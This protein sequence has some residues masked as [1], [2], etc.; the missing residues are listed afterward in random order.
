MDKIIKCPKCG[1]KAEKISLKDELRGKILRGTVFVDPALIST[2]F[3][4]TIAKHIFKRVFRCPEC[5]HEWS[6][7]R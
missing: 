1:A 2:P 4:G 7:W 6:E 5:N 3:S